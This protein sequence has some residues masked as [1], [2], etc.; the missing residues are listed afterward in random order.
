MRKRRTIIREKIKESLFSVLPVTLTVAIIA[1]TFADISSGTFL[2]FLIGSLFLIVGMA[3]F[4]LG[5]DISMTK[6]GEFVGKR[7]TASKKLWHIVLLSFLVGVM[8]TVSEPDLTVLA[9]QVSDAVSKYLLIIAVGIGVGIFLVLAMLRIVFGV[10]LSYLLFASYA[11]VF[12]MLFFVPENFIP[13]SFDSGGVTT[14]PMTVPFIMALGVG[15]ASIRSDENAESDAFGLVALCSVGPI[16][17]VM[18]LGAIFKPDN[19]SW[20]LEGIP[21]SSTV[22]ITSSFIEHLPEKLLEV[23]ISLLPIIIFFLIYQFFTEKLSRKNIAKILIGSAYTYFGLVIFLTGASCGFMQTGYEIGRSIS[24]SSL[25]FLIVPIGCIIG[26]STV[27]AEPAVAVLEKQVEDVT[28]GSIPKKLLGGALSIGVAVSVGIA[29]LRALTG[30][31]ILYFLI[32][33]YLV[34][35]GL[36]FVTPPIFTSIAFDSGGVASG[37]MTATFLLPLAAGVCEGV[38]G[39]IMT[40][41]FGVV[42][43]VAVTPLVAIQ[44]LGLVYKYKTAKT[45]KQSAAKERIEDNSDIIEM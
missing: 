23:A 44:I 7:M 31:S 43:M 18:I 16:L 24:E 13:L 19:S 26:F 10:K 15:A 33:C 21:S 34:A 5:A 17:A 20:T 39:N 9:E 6:M 30:I 27:K 3:F 11:I 12:I 41:A 2:S 29:M 35:L 1:F 4:S 42:A 32:P 14:G 28:S 8:I 25:A 37:P 22:E 45:Q 40:D 38:G 36:T